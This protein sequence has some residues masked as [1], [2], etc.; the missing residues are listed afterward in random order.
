MDGKPT[1]SLVF[2]YRNYKMYDEFGFSH[3]KHIVY[4]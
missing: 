4:I 3:I 1:F 2:M